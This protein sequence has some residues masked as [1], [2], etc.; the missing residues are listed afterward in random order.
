MQW[1]IESLFDNN[2]GN[3]GLHYAVVQNELFTMESSKSEIA[4]L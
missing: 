1:L 2:L 3:L 4:Y